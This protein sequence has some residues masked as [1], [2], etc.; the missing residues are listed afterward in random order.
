VARPEDAFTFARH[1]DCPDHLVHGQF[2]DDLSCDLLN[3][4]GSAGATVFVAYGSVAVVPSTV[5]ATVMTIGAALHVIPTPTLNFTIQVRSHRRDVEGG[6]Q[7]AERRQTA[8][9]SKSRSKLP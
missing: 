8:N 6:E 4:A 9:E 5:D 3:A 7:K 1:R 2:L